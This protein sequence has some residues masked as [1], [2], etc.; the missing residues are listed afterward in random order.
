MLISPLLVSPKRIVLVGKSTI[1]STCSWNKI[2]VKA[3][4]T[5]WEIFRSLDSVLMAFAA[6]A[7]PLVTAL[8]MRLYNLLSMKCL[9][10]HIAVCLLVMVAGIGNYM[11][12]T[13]RVGRDGYMDVAVYDCRTPI[14]QSRCD[15]ERCALLVT[16][17][18]RD[19]GSEQ[20]HR[21]ARKAYTLRQ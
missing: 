13:A 2:K 4:I 6:F 14:P 5:F 20:E 9:G 1:G 7:T 16:V 3:T 12:W 21:R 17:E 15:G 10:M 8:L 19:F 11:K 18:K